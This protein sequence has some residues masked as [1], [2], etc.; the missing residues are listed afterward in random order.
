MYPY[1]LPPQLSYTPEDEERRLEPKTTMKSVYRD[2]VTN[3]IPLP[4]WLWNLIVVFIYLNMI[5][6][7]LWAGAVVL[8]LILGVAFGI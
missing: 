4:V 6:V 8:A 7:M 3:P 5:V 1:V 2:F